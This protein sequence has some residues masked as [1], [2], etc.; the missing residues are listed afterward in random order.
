MKRERGLNFG[1][2][3]RMGMSGGGSGFGGGVLM[4]GAWCRLRVMINGS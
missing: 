1:D 3:L 4:D 2:G